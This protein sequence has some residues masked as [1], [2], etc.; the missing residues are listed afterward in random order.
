MSTPAKIALATWAAYLAL[1]GLEVL[2]Y[3]WKR[4]P[5]PWREYFVT[6]AV[7]ASELVVGYL[8][9]HRLAKG[10]EPKGLGFPF[11]L[12]S[13]MLPLLAHGRIFAVLLGILVGD[14]TFYV[15][16]Y[17]HH[18][19]P[20]FWVYHSTHH[21]SRKMHF[22]LGVREGVFRYVIP[23]FGIPWLVMHAPPDWR[24]AYLGGIAFV[25]IWQR[26]VH[27][28][29]FPRMGWLDYVLITP[30]NHRVHHA[31]NVG[32]A[33]NVGGFTT[34]WDHLFGTFLTEPSDIRLEY[35][36][37]PALHTDLPVWRYQFYALQQ[38]LG[39]I[40]TAPGIVRKTRA[41]LSFSDG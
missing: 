27:S 11:A 29:F 37:D 31:L 36:M 9:G 20:L 25:I 14:L 19:F 32:M 5:Y 12:E 26:L 10:L 6:L 34:L 33:R 13:Q 21:S 3:L 35:G 38:L 7:V 22:L 4:R 39:R 2:S 41:L 15:T 23:A 30:S 40:W 8:I 28:E 24:M 16:H 18:R 17:I 1:S